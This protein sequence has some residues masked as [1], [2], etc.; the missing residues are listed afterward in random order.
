MLELPSFNK[1]FQMYTNT[2]GIFYVELFIAFMYYV[3]PKIMT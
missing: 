3:G 1:T 2:S